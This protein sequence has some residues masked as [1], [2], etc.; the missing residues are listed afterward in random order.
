MISYALNLVSDSPEE[1]EAY[2]IPGKSDVRH[3]A[4]RN[5]VNIRTLDL[6]YCFVNQVSLIWILE[7]DTEE[8]DANNTNLGHDPVTQEVL[9][10]AGVSRI[11]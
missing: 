7:V 6:F 1:I 4:L 9:L 11:K 8:G 10:Q 5:L 3:H 2:N